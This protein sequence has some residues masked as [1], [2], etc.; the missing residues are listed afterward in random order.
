MDALRIAVALP[1]LGVYG[2]IR[3]FLE[4]GRVWTARGHEVALL[5]PASGAAERPWLPFP[6]K[7]GTL[8]EL[9]ARPWDVLLSPDPELFLQSKPPGALRV[10]YAVLEGAPRAREAW[11]D[12]DLVL[13]NSRGMA[14]HLARH[15]V[16]AVH[17]P[18]GVNTEFFRPP[19]PDPRPARAGAGEPVRALVYGRLSRRRKGSWTAVRAIEAASAASRVAVS[20]T[21]FD[22]PPPGTPEPALG[23]DLGVPFQWVLRPTQEELRALYS[24]ADLFVSAERRAGWS[25]TTAEAMASGAAVVCTP[26]GTEDFAENGVTAAVARWPWT[27]LL[28]RKIAPLLLDAGERRALAQR[29]RERIGEFTWERTA[30]RIEQALEAALAR[31]K[32]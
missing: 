32:R 15:R 18:G 22:T 23:R 26:S 29:G 2:G 5:T 21:L 19:D 28:A 27:W 30:D 25:N 3:R 7:V 8:E 6:G 24:E 14:R 31:R 20:L 17:V 12:A 1:H 10:F 11:R 9:R 16:R 13:A 4:L